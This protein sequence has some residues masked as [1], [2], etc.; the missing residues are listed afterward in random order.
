MNQTAA[1]PIGLGQK[2]MYEVY[3]KEQARKN[4]IIDYGLLDVM[5]ETKDIRYGQMN[6]PRNL[7]PSM[8]ELL[9]GGYE[10][11][12]VKGNNEENEQFDFKNMTEEQIKEFTEAYARKEISKGKWMTETRD[13]FR[14]FTDNPADNVYYIGN[15]LVNR[16][17]PANQE[18]LKAMDNCHFKTSYHRDFGEYES[19]GEGSLEE[20]ETEPEAEEIIN[21]K[22]KNLRSKSRSRS[23]G[24]KI[25]ER[26][27]TPKKR[28]KDFNKWLFLRNKAK[29]AVDPI[30]KSKLSK[31]E[32]EELKLLE[33]EISVS[34]WKADTHMKSLHGKPIFHPYGKGNTNP[35]TGGVVY[36]E[37]LLTH[38][39]HPHSGANRPAYQQVYDSAHNKAFVN[40]K[41]NLIPTK[42]LPEPVQISKEDMED[43]KTRNPIM[44]DKPS[45]QYNRE[46][47]QLDLVNEVC[48]ASKHSTPA[49][50][51]FIKTERSSKMPSTRKKSV[52]NSSRTKPIDNKFKKKDIRRKSKKQAR[53]IE[54][55]P[56]EVQQN[57][58]AE[59]QNYTNGGDMKASKNTK[60]ESTAFMK[61][62]A[63]TGKNNTKQLDQPQ[64]L[65]NAHEEKEMRTISPIQPLE[66]ENDEKSEILV[67]E[68]NDQESEYLNDKI[69]ESNENPA[70]N[71][72][73]FPVGFPF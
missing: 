29:Y 7:E 15:Q 40:G 65:K 4:D 60:N 5:H 3:I 34:R 66:T 13:N 72:N 9:T 36:G 68:E 27:G 61:T 58:L 20:I 25:R 41:P 52:E 73:L 23:P 28:K 12:K 32:R 44:P 31:K 69:N 22:P 16:N 30:D 2:A 45:R 26:K 1:E 14:K 11:Q 24:T 17:N 48:F 49:T 21:K 35:T 63:S 47:K 46:V 43:L 67:Q 54:A 57:A 33:N 8:N 37:Y 62:M 53:L 51:E 19:E 39:I 6:K 10:I 71:P 18:D 50:S 59:I 64:T 38:N 42:K 56:E 55:T 70:V